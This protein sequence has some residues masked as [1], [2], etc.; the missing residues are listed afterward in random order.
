MTPRDGDGSVALRIGR[1]QH[2]VMSSIPGAPIPYLCPPSPP[3]N[4]WTMFGAVGGGIAVVAGFIVMLVG[5]S[6]QNRYAA[7]PV[8]FL[9]GLSIVGL[10]VLLVLCAFVLAGVDWYLRHPRGP[11]AVADERGEAA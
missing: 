4:P 8:T 10:G 2:G 7:S 3:S 1:T 5:A 9:V 6:D 11:G